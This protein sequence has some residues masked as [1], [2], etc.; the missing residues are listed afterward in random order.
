M[1]DFPD[2][3]QF[4]KM[5]QEAITCESDGRYSEATKAM[6]NVANVYDSLLAYARSAD[7][8]AAEATDRVIRLSNEHN[9]ALRDVGALRQQLERM[10]RDMEIAED[11]IDE[12]VHIIDVYEDEG[13]ADGV[14]GRTDEEL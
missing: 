13:G 5:L 2:E 11:T 4:Y 12:L 3:E 1:D 6:D 14:F 10:K 7:E 9:I 8:R